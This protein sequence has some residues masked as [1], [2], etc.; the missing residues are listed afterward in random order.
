[1][2]NR[3]SKEVVDDPLLPCYFLPRQFLQCNEPVG[4]KS[5]PLILLLLWLWPGG[6]SRQFECPGSFGP[7]L[8]E[9]KSCHLVYNTINLCSY[10]CPKGM[11]ANVGRRWKPARPAA[12]SILQEWKQFVI[13]SAINGLE[14]ITSMKCLLSNDMKCLH[15]PNCRHH[16]IYQCSGCW[17][18]LSAL[19]PEPFLGPASPAS[20]TPTTIS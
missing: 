6:P 3:S 8:L 4:F 10:A 19:V 14:V 18:V 7:R 17:I 15:H 1:M 12:G 16:A 13:L 5:V 2:E 20:D 9:V 11:E